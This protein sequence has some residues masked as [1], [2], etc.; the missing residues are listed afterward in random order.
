[1]AMPARCGYWSFALI[2]SNEK[3]AW[4]CRSARSAERLNR[5]LGIINVCHDRCLR[6]RRQ[7]VVVSA[8]T[9]LLE[10]PKRGGNVSDRRRLETFDQRFD[11]PV[12]IPR[13]SGNPAARRLQ[14]VMAKG[15][16]DLAAEWRCRVAGAPSPLPDRCSGR[17]RICGVDSPP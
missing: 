9:C 15:S 1:M 14:I 17:G 6:E 10:L 2:A 4:R 5:L 11:A 16:R 13:P 7:V 12:D 3:N 8:V